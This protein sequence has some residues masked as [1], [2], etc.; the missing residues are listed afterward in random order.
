MVTHH[1]SQHALRWILCHGIRR[2]TS[3]LHFVCMLVFFRLT[4]VM[5]CTSVIQFLAFLTKTL[6]G[7]GRLKYYYITLSKQKDHKLSHSLEAN[8]Y[9]IKMR[10]TIF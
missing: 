6:E 7:Y 5:Q 10:S 2:P 9:I 8:A 1:E 4:R 3:S